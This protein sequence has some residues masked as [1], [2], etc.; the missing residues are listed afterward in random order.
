MCSAIFDKKKD[1]ELKKLE[2][3]YSYGEIPQEEYLEIKIK[4]LNAEY[5]DR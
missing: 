1:K 4:L 3:M 5:D 2:E